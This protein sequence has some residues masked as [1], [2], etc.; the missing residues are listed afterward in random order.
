MK[1]GIITVSDKGVKGERE[2]LSGKKIRALVKADSY[3][4]CVVP[5]E[6]EQIF[7]AI[8]NFVDN[9][10]CNLVF[11]TG[12]TGLSHRDITPE[13]TSDAI[14]R[15]IPGISE[16][17]RIESFKINKRSVLSRA[18]SGSRGKSLIVNLPGSPKAVEECLEII[19]PVIPH[20][21]D[22][23]EQGSV[24]CGNLT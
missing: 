16:I 19:L 18:V 14:D 7:N 9:K 1:L 20:A 6:K 13:A 21:L 24:E 22:V 11:T 4:Y 10:A 5:D 15:P 17:I 12:G 2:D 23:L 8:I 3:E